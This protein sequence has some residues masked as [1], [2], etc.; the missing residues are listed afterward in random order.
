MMGF[1]NAAS[2]Q[3]GKQMEDQKSSIAIFDMHAVFEIKSPDLLEIIAA[4]A[5]QEIE[6]A[7]D[8]TNVPCIDGFCSGQN[9]VCA[10][11]G[12]CSYTD[13]SCIYNG[14]CPNYICF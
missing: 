4:G 2:T 5:S 3:M 8:N 7:N 1:I 11:N 12:P 6:A 14:G 10:V 13:Y 9:S